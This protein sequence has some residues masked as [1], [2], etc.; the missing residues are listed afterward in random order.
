MNGEMWAKV[1]GATV[2]FPIALV[3]CSGALDALGSCFPGLASRR[4][5]HAAG[6][7]TMMLGAMGTVPAVFSGLVMSKGVMLGHDALRLHHLFVWPAFALI[8]GVAAWRALGS[9]FAAQKPPVGYLAAVGVAASLVMAAG[10]WGGE[11]LLKN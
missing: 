11:M 7:W 10:Y 6:Y 1:H 4:G 5:L 2:H 8:A 9:D 3:L